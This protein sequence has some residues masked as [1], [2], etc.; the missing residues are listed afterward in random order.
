MCLFVTYEIIDG[1]IT[2]GYN[3]PLVTGVRYTL[4]LN[5]VQLPELA[6]SSMKN[7][8]ILYGGHLVEKFCFPNNP[9]L[10]YEDA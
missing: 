2:F 9:N 4:T 8:Y 1:N 10:C 7:N 3:K 5:N 6:I